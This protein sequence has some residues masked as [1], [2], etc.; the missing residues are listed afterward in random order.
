MTH[1]VAVIQAR[2]GSTRL[3]GKVMFPLSGEPVLAHVVRRVATAETVDEVVVATSTQ[4]NDDIVARYAERFGATAFRGSEEDVLG[5]VH[6]AAADCDADLVVRITADCPLIDPDTIDHLVERVTRTNAQYVSNVRDRTFPR[7]LDTEVF[8]MASFDTV[9]AESTTDAQREHVTP[10][11][12]AH[13]ERFDLADVTSDAVFE[14]SWMRERTDLRLTLDEADDYELLRTVYDVVPF[15]RI[16]PVTRAVRYIDD[17]GLDSINRQ[18]TQKS[19]HD[20]S[21]DQG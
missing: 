2:T 11:Y 19:I 13:P 7:G 18:I 12:R 21:D 3:P 9:T 1:T 15:D 17:L 10:F 20:A 16:L 14:Q 8:T 4:Q 6:G 5:R